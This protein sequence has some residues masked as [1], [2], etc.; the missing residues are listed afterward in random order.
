MSDPDFC[1]AKVTSPLGI[2]ELKPEVANLIYDLMISV[3]HYGP[4]EYGSSS[5]S[6]SECGGARLEMLERVSDLALRRG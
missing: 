3:A 5:M 6:M 4:I 2:D 1:Y